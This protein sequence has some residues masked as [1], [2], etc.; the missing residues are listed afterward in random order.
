M[1]VLTPNQPTSPYCER[2]LTRDGWQDPWGNLLLLAT[3]AEQ[4]EAQS[5][6]VYE[7][8]AETEY[9]EVPESAT[10]WWQSAVDA[11]RGL[12]LPY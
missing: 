5:S 12:A 7:L 11:L 3:V 4:I 8:P 2:I 6:E 10:P 1:F 9:D